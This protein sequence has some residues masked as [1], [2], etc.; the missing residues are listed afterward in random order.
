MGG[1]D[2][3]VQKARCG[4]ALHGC[5]FPSIGR[6]R[7]EGVGLEWTD[8]RWLETEAHALTIA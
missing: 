6:R 1:G 2:R 5:G 4:R 3:G 7:L 8:S